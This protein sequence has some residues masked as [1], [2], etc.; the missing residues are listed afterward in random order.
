MLRGRILLKVVFSDV[1][2]HFD[3]GGDVPER[4]TELLSERELRGLVGVE[5]GLRTR[6]LLLHFGHLHCRAHCAPLELPGARSTE[7]VPP[8]RLVERAE[9]RGG[10]PARA[11]RAAIR[12]RRATAGRDRAGLPAQDM[13]ARLTR[14]R[15][16]ACTQQSS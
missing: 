8:V 13:G 11:H 1:R 9:S 3:G 14:R 15:L 5:A 12:A 10:R 16:G 2:V 4:V 7:Q 6:H